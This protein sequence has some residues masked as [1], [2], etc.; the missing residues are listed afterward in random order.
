MIHRKYKKN[1]FMTCH[2][3][4]RESENSEVEVIV[5]AKLSI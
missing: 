1:H 4:K 5:L 2:L 3:A